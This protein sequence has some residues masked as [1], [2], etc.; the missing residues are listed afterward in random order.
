MLDKVKVNISI[1]SKKFIDLP[2][3][4]LFRV[5]MTIHSFKNLQTYTKM[6]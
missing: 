4:Y 3:Y 6:W 5:S 1:V 2:S